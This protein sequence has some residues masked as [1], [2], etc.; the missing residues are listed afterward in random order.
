MLSRHLLI[1][2]AV[3]GL[4]CGCGFY[5]RRGEWA[6]VMEPTEPAPLLSDSTSLSLYDKLSVYSV[7]C[8]DGLSVEIAGHEEFSGDVGVDQRGRMVLP[9]TEDLLEVEGLS[10]DEVEGRVA[11]AVAPYVVGR[12]EVNVSL[13]S[14]ASKFYYV[15]GGVLKPGVYPMGGNVI[16][17]REA[18][19]ISGF[20]ESEAADRRRVGIVTPDPERP[21]YLIA[22]G[23]KIMLGVDRHNIILKPGDVVFVQNRFVYDLDRFLYALFI[24][25]ENVSTTNRAVEFWE[26]VLDGEFGDFAAPDRGVTIVY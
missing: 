26:G 6:D 19:G 3:V 12:P 13:I 17:L 20:F 8:G 1:A 2:A 14:S 24:T 25:T 22:N 10:L 4:L 16:R 21:T 7:G 5:G 23:R 9:N 15:L 18:L 11:E